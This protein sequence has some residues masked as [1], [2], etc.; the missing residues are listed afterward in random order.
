MI[1]KRFLLCKKT[2]CLL[3]VFNWFKGHFHMYS[4]VRLSILLCY[5]CLDLS[6]KQPVPVIAYSDFLQ[7]IQQMLWKMNIQPFVDCLC[8]INLRIISTVRLRTHRV[9]SS[10]HTWKGKTAFWLSFTQQMLRE[11]KH[12]KICS[13]CVFKWFVDHFDIC[14]S[15]S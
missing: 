1:N 8:L 3:F 12:A 7:C 11:K 10:S 13:L 6:E 9:C 14:L 5:S 2:F 15:T 4:P